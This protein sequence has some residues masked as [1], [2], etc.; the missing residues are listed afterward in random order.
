[1][2]TSLDVVNQCLA[3][4]GE[5]PLN[6]LAEDHAFKQA[7]LN[8]L[9]RNDG[10][11]QSEGWW[12]NTED[13]TLAA[14]PAD[15]R[16]YLPTDAATIRPEGSDSLRYVQ[17]GR[18]LYDLQGGT[19]RFDAGFTLAVKLV[20]RV[21]FADIPASVNA[22]VA[23]KSVLDFQNEYDGDQTKTRNLAAEVNGI[24]GVALGLKGMAEA[25]HIRNI[26]YNFVTES[27]RLS[28]IT[29]RVNYSR[30]PR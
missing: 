16:V 30:R 17:R 18:V 19:D 6:T 13:L 2:A 4:M 9:D 27:E 11:I 21:P 3:V 26:R 28:R 22:Y 12:F 8:I 29:N 5:A 20:R 7:A 25:E 23:R 24:P 15:S 10:T 14:S 1:M